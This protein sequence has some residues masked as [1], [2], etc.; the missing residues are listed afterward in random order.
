[1]RRY[2]QQVRNIVVTS[3]LADGSLLVRGN[4]SQLTQLFMNVIVNAEE[5]VDR[6]AGKCIVITAEVDAEWARISVADSGGGVP[7]GNLGQVFF[8]FF[9]TKRMGE[10]TGLGLSTCHGIVTAHGGLIRAE[11]NDIG[12]ATF[13]IELPLA[14]E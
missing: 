2:Q 4:T 11:N 12:G 13:V 8:P 5:A 7:E 1:M 9:T 6:S 14:G 3:N 10:G